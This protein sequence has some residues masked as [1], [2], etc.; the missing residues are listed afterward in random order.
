MTSPRTSTAPTG[1]VKALVKGVAA[2]NALADAP[3]GLALGEIAA[4]TGLS[5]ATAHRILVTLA[6]ARLVQALGDGRYRLGPHCLQLAD[7]FV[8]G[9]DIRAVA[10]PRLR[11]LAATTRET[12]HLGVLSG[13]DV[14][15]L[16]RIESPHPV[17]M[18]SRLGATSPA[19]TTGLGRAMLAFS[20][21]DTVEAVLAAG[22]PARTPQTVTD[23]AV[24]RERLAAVRG[25]GYALDDV[26]NEAGIRC[27]AAPVLGR[28]GAAVAAISVS[29]PEHRLTAADVERVG[30]LVRA[31]AESI[32]R[33][34]GLDG[35]FP[36]ADA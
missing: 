19:T 17:R 34:L 27:V 6:A 24:A 12:C 1:E 7:A 3:D 15:Y 26:E 22:I 30:G 8:T 16:E 29:A 2:L 23:P 21:P 32:S 33:G 35:A 9:L 18:Y 4:R 36:G 31:A 10:L 13:A 20:P 5:K 11:E 28:D 25:Y 14:V